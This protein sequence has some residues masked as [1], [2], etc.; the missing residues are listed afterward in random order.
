MASPVTSAPSSG[1]PLRSVSAAV[2]SLAAGVAPKRRHQGLRVETLEEVVIGGVAGRAPAL[3]SKQPQRF[4]PQPATPAPDRPEVVRPRQHRRQGDPQN[5]PQL[6]LP[7]L[8]PTPIRHLPERIPQQPRHGQ[9]PPQRPPSQAIK[10]KP[11]SPHACGLLN[12]PD[13]GPWRPFGNSPGVRA[14]ARPNRP[15]RPL[16]ARLRDGPGGAKPGG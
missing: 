12:H 15:V 7:T 11:S 8:P 2:I 16:Q 4:W 9:P 13:T 3:D 10:P 6:V 5:R 1:S 14:R